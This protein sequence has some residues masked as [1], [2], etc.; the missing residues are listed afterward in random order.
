MSENSLPFVKV[1]GQSFDIDPG[2]SVFS[3]LFREYEYVVFRSIITSFGLDMFITDRHGGD[4]D[5]IHNVRTIGYDPLMEYKNTQ[6]QE[7]YQNRGTYDHK[8]VEG[9]N[10]N[11]QRI[12]KEARDR[13]H[14]DPRNNTVS[15][16]YENKE[17]HFLGNS[18]GRPTDKNANLDHVIAAKKI[19]DDAGRVLAGVSTQQLADDESNLKF[20]NEHLNKSMKDRDIPDYLADEKNSEIPEEVQK[21]MMNAYDEAT[22]QY[23][24]TIAKSLYFDFDN[25]NCRKFYRDTAEAALNRGVEMGIRQ[26][27]GFL[28]TEL[29]FSVKDALDAS[30][31]T[32]E[33]ACK[34]IISGLEQGVN[35]A[36]HNYS[37]LFAQFGQG[38]MSGILASVSTTIINIFFTTSANAGRIIRQSWASV[39]EATSIVFFGDRDQYMCDRITS[40]AKVIATGASAIVGMEV[41]DKVEQA[42]TPIIM[43]KELKDIVAVFSGSLCTGLLSVTLLFYIDND[44]FA[45][46]LD[47]SY[48]VTK[49]QLELQRMAF[50]KHCANLQNIDVKKLSSEIR[51]V[52]Q[53]LIALESAESQTQIN[54]ILCST[55]RIMGLPSIFGDS[56]LDEKM[57][58]PN[59]VLTI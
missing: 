59:W 52:N 18:K 42:L 51:C 24:F 11:Y 20:T 15:D 6:N 44:P 37:V 47:Y 19:H 57:S 41:Q 1:L 34:A 8:N 27:A 17:L 36:R 4:V 5:T 25:P 39:V 7:A 31:G 23:E 16:A 46:A 2:E 53:A 54:E 29:W 58:D 45:K 48:G 38:V 40:A 3:A 50:Q 30:D 49:R 32:F 28:F 22:E 26:A 43:P 55:V 35:S 21:R 56:T 33:G 13:Y 12:K 10:T 14:E 9:P